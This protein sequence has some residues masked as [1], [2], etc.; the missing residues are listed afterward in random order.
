MTR[1]LEIF[2]PPLLVFCLFLLIWQSVTVIFDVPSFLIP[3][4]VQVFTVA[5]Q[6]APTLLMASGLT[7]AGALG[8]FFSSFLVGLL[9]AFAFSQSYLIQRSFYPYAIFLQTVPIVA[10][11]PLIIIWF[12]TGFF[13][14]VLVSFIIS[15]FPIITNGTAGLTRISPHLFD[16]FAINN[17]S[18]WQILWKLRLPNAVPDL[19]TGA[20]I[21]SGLSVIGAIVGEFFAGYG[22]DQYGLGYLIIVTS[23]QLKTAYLFAA[24]L[25]STMLGLL[26]FGVVSGLG[27]LLLIRWQE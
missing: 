18:R 15:V 5:W 16:L 1:L 11:A 4:P 17:A 21:S 6:N 19:V 10:I 7:T 22:T 20:K 13:S 25:M 9:V 26:I 14:V 12:G 8:G 23:G 27:N 2:V 24:I 3:A